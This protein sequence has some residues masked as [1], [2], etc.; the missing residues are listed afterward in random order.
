MQ[1]H[2]FLIGLDPK[3]KIVVNMLSSKMLEKAYDLTKREERNLT[4][5][6]TFLKYNILDEEDK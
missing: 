2:R 3:I 6:K 4:I 5:K 1:V